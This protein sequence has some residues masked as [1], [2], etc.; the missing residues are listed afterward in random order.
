M[1]LLMEG[2]AAVALL[3]WHLSNPKYVCLTKPNFVHYQALS[4]LYVIANKPEL[5]N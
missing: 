1:F 3:G 5:V 2:L 4:D